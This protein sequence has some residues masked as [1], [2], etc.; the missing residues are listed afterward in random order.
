[1]IGFDDQKFARRAYEAKRIV[2]AEANSRRI[3]SITRSLRRRSG[4]LT[5]FAGSASEGLALSLS[6]HATG[7]MDSQIAKTVRRGHEIQYSL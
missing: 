3:F 4:S 2:E 6:S 5:I 1:L 7:A